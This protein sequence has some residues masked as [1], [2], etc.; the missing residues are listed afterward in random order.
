M[1]S[2]PTPEQW[3]IHEMNEME[4]AEEIEKHINFVDED[5]RSVHLQM[6]FVR[7]F[8]QRH[9][10]GLPIIVAIATL[11]IIL[12]DGGILAFEDDIDTLRGID[13]VI[14]KEVMALL[15]RREDCTPD[16][17]KKAMK[18]LTDEW[19]CD[20]KT[21][22]AGKGVVDRR[23]LEHHRTLAVAQ[24]PRLLCYRRPAREWQN[25]GAHH[26]DDGRH[27]HPPGSCGMVVE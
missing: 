22:Y 1:T 2:L 15:P 21:D 3:V 27:R 26:V 5:G 24:S 8:L 12:A 4:M 14:P 16:A 20:V 23:S 19:L 10:D 11:P 18:F 9:D 7:H 25:H 13:F 6:Q 17:V